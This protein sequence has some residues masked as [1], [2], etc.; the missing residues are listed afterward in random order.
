[1]STSL[2]AERFRPRVLTALLP[3]HVRPGAA[4]ALVQTASLGVVFCAI[5]VT[6]DAAWAL[7]AARAR[8]WLSADSRRLAAGSLCGGLVM[9]G[10]A[11][12]L[13]TSTPAS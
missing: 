2:S 8:A 7:A 1:M 3:Q 10:L 12:I 9:I 11:L 5:A 4:P 13:A 6:C